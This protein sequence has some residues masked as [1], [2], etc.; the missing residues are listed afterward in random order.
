MFIRTYEHGHPN[1]CILVTNMPEHMFSSE[2]SPNMTV[3]NMIPNMIFRTW[4]K[5]ATFGCDFCVAVN[6]KLAMWWNLQQRPRLNIS[7]AS[8]RVGVGVCD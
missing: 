3:P 4:S 5:N 6:W 1:M 8:L 2:H 7:T